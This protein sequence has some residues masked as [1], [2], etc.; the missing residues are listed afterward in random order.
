MRDVRRRCSLRAPEVKFEKEEFPMKNLKKVLALGL[1]LVMILGMFTIASA[2]ETKKSAAD[3]TDWDKVEHKDA[4]ALA[5]DL[6]IINGLPDGSFGP[7]QTIDRASWAKLVYFTATGDDNADAYLGTATGLKDIAGNWAESYINYLFANKY[8]AG[9]GLGNYMPTGTVTVAAGLKTMLTVL[10]YDAD[11][12]GYQN[13]AAWAGNIMTDAKRNGL[14]DEI[15]RSQTAMV[16]LT[17]DNAAQIVYNA[18]QAQTVTPEYRRDQGVSYVVSYEKGAT[19][20]RDVFSILPVTAKVASVN[21]KGVATFTEMDPSKY[22]ASQLS[23]VKASSA[24]VGETVTVFIKVKGS[25]N[26]FDS[27]V[28]TSVAKAASS[29]AKVFTKGVA[30]S[31]ITTEK[32]DDY[33]GGAADTIT[34]YLNGASST[35]AAVTEHAAKAGNKVEVFTADGKVNMIKVTTYTVKK[36][37]ADPETRTRNDELQVRVNGIIAWTAA[38]K[39]EGY[40]GLAEDDIVL[41]N[42]DNNGNVVFE[43][44]EKVTG[45]VTSKRGG[46]LTVAGTQYEE[47]GIAVT[48]DNAPGF[49]SWDVS[50]NKDNEYDFYLDINGTVC[51]LVKVSGEA[52]KEVAYVLQTGFNPAGTGINAASA[53]VELELLFTDG[54]TEIVKVAKI[55]DK[56]EDFVESDATGLNGKLIDFSVNSKGNY[57][58]TA[59]TTTNITDA[60]ITAEPKFDTTNTANNKTVFL[61]EKTN[62]DDD[63]EFFVYTGYKNVPKM[64]SASGVAFLDDGVVTY[65]FLKTDKFAG[66][67]SD[68]LIYIKDKE[69]YD[70][71]TDG[72]YV[73]EIVDAEGSETT[74][75]IDTDKELEVGFYQIT[76]VS[77]NVA[78]VTATTETAAE[79]LKIGNGVVAAGSN[80]YSYDNATVAVVIDIDEE[81]AFDSASVFSP[82]NFEVDDGTSYTYSVIV[83][84]SDGNAEYIYVV[85]TAV[86]ADGV[87]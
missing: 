25:T 44:A 55:G 52:D 39:V 6:G 83:M 16:N 15:D 84:A 61:V 76:S 69:A 35:E 41:V 62:G 75:A 58:V 2:A 1:A 24:L 63:S 45:K 27:V 17:R 26:E 59:K 81:G 78:T 14:M 42:T 3:F 12:R 38:D 65:A 48:G 66:D 68:G 40:Q 20:G 79:T 53:S 37:G 23:D 86:A 56:D 47:S 46:K 32:K 72:K 54:S 71:N 60:K 77:D 19:L 74:L 80:T 49:A 28:S 57:E 11:D 5:V 30:L 64:D 85:R 50:G 13:D 36:V 4:V 73:Y 51:Y 87:A 43:K 9:D 82:D 8:I 31:D 33:V 67:G 21:D 70:L 10:G 18:L 34:Y 29:A 7:D 22:T